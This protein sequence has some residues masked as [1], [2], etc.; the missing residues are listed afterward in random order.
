MGE[1]ISTVP[2]KQCNYS[3]V[4]VCVNE[5]ERENGSLVYAGNLCLNV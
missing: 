1:S 4:C 2:W 5:R 3:V